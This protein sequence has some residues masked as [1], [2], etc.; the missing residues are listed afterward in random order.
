MIRD[1]IERR[2]LKKAFGEYIDPRIIDRLID[3]PDSIPLLKTSPK[4]V[5]YLII[6]IRDEDL[7]NLS[8]IIGKAIDIALESDAIVQEICSSLIV[9]TFGGFEFEDNISPA[10]QKNKRLKLLHTLQIG[11]G[12]TKLTL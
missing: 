8:P 5:D 1:W 2:K 7:N 9:F 11:R 3:D 6:L 4:N 12:R 10:E